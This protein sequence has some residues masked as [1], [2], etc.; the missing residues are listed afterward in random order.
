MARETKEQKEARWAAEAQ[1]ALIAKE[2]FKKTMP[3]RLMKLQELASE[4]SVSTYVTLT[5]TGPAIE[6][7]RYD[8]FNDFEV[9]LTYDSEEWE[10]DNLEHLMIVI[11]EEIDARKARQTSAEK[12]W[13]SM[14]DDERK[15]LKENIAN[16]R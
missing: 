16:F 6:F 9:T 4:S 13:Q 8:Q 3:E 2:T 1:T 14:T 10:V 12:L 11:K 5:P 7:T 15:S